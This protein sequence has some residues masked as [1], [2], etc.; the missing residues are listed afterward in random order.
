MRQFRVAFIELICRTVNF[1]ET[2]EIEM[3]VFGAQNA[4][5]R[6][7][8][9]QG[10]GATDHQNVEQAIMNNSDNHN[11]DVLPQQE[12]RVVYSCTE[13]CAVYKISSN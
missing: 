8:K 4:A 11:I 9:R 7:E 12:N 2:E 10:H 3:R 13:Y 1:S 6:L 5:V